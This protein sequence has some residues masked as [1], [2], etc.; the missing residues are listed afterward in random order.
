MFSTFPFEKVPLDR[1]IFLMSDRWMPEFE[2][3]TV[4]MF[5][6]GEYPIVGYVAYA[7]ARRVTAHAMELSWYPNISDRFHEVKVILPRSEFVTCVG[8]DDYDLKP[9]VFVHDAWLN[10]LYIRA[11][12]VFLLID[13]I[14]VKK[15]I[16]AGRLRRPHLIKLR[17]AIDKLAEGY[18]ELAFVSFADSLLIKGNWRVGHVGSGV[19]YSYEPETFVR[20]VPKVAEI[21]RDVLN[22]DVYAVFTQGANEYYED[23]P[24]HVSTSGNHLSLNS[25]GLPFAQLLAIDSAAREAIRAKVHGPHELYMDEDFYHSLSFVFKFNKNEKPHAHYRDPMSEQWSVYYYSSCQAIMDNLVS[26]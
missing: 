20:I 25:L 26:K 22:L 23:A 6:G 9:Y 12:S 17:D 2:K 18:P 1:D 13:A 16:R 3:A 15:E 21:Y 14:G 10:Q 11:Y 8:C 19:T 4:A 7:A 24:S 5:D